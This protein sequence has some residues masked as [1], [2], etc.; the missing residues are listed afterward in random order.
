RKLNDNERIGQTALGKYPFSR[1]NTLIVPANDTLTLKPGNY[2]FEEIKLEKGAK[3]VITS[4]AIRLSRRGNPQSAIP[5]VRIFVSGAVDLRQGEIINQT[6]DPSKLVIISSESSKGC[7]YLPTIGTF[8]AGV[9]APLTSIFALESNNLKITGAI[10][11]DG[12]KLSGSVTIAY[13]TRILNIVF[14]FPRDVDCGKKWW[15]P[16]PPY[17]PGK[18]PIITDFK[19][20]PDPAEPLFV[21]EERVYQVV[22][23]ATGSL[24][25]E[26]PLETFPSY[27]APRLIY[28]LPQDPALVEVVGIHPME[29]I[30]RLGCLEA[31]ETGVYLELYVPTN[32][33]AQQW[34]EKTVPCNQIPAGPP[35][36]PSNLVATAVSS[37]QIDLTWTDN[38]DNEDGFKIEVKIDGIEDFVQLATADADVTNYSTIRVL[39][40]IIHSYR[41]CAYNEAGNSDYSNIA[42]ATPLGDLTYD[43]KVADGYALI[44][45]FRPTDYNSVTIEVIETPEPCELPHPAASGVSIGEITSGILNLYYYDSADQC[46]N[47][48]R[49]IEINNITR[50]IYYNGIPVTTLYQIFSELSPA[51]A[52]DFM[53]LLMDFPY[54]LTIYMTPV[55]H[56]QLQAK[57]GRFRT[58]KPSGIDIWTI[59]DS[60]PPPPPISPD[61]PPYGDIP[62]DVGGRIPIPINGRM[63]TIDEL[64]RTGEITPAPKGI[65]PTDSYDCHGWTFLCARGTLQTATSGTRDDPKRA[66][67]G[68]IISANGYTR[69]TNT[70]RVHVGALATYGAGDPMAGGVVSHTGIVREVMV[71][72]KRTREYCQ[73]GTPTLVESKWGRLGRYLHPPGTVPNGYL[74]TDNPA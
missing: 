61:W 23:L 54:W 39:T 38:S 3:L 13:D 67:I 73:R 4:S 72:G 9:Y 49:N 29:L 47:I 17:E 1:L 32:P 52:G 26:V 10:I 41:V 33:P 37:S 43:G 19:V 51:P 2:Y 44:A 27:L 15:G 60:F 57:V 53:F 20:V 14:C 66:N 36:A 70:Q 18:Y 24:T 25:Y 59:P 58:D 42:S 63:T 50:V 16:P 22:L 46:I 12:I 7:I 30:Y 64:L 31:G 74:P 45:V 5:G 48:N 28:V 56:N 68:G 8:C 55:S 34:P 65:T 71:D 21:G 11:A 62:V 69:I 35:N 6:N 40:G